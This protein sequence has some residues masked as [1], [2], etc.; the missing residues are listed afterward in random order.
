MR[1]TG[2]D[3][4]KFK[5]DGELGIVGACRVFDHYGGVITEALTM[6]ASEWKLMKA[7][8]HTSK[9][10]VTFKY[11]GADPI[12]QGVW[13]MLN[14]R[15]RNAAY[16]AFSSTAVGQTA[17][18][19]VEDHL[20]NA[21][22]V[23]MGKAAPQGSDSAIHVDFELK[24]KEAL[25]IKNSDLTIGESVDRLAAT[26]EA[27]VCMGIEYKTS[28]VIIA[29]AFGMKEASSSSLAS[30]V[31]RVAEVARLKTEYTIALY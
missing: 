20:T 25:K 31:A 3:H 5:G 4:N 18:H 26:S 14:K 21:K 13:D 7:S 19:E 24:M 29:T 27:R 2:L 6:L 8:K 30:R 11:E 15:E 22:R 12:I 16:S 17:V 1:I 10:P 23:D 9:L 28:T